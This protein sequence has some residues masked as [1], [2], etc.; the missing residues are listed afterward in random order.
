MR[1]LIESEGQTR[2]WTKILQLPPGMYE[3]RYVVDGHWCDDPDNPETVSSD[4]ESQT[5]AEIAEEEVATAGKPA[6]VFTGYLETAAEPE[7]AV[8]SEDGRHP[9]HNLAYFASFPPSTSSRWL[10]SSR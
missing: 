4:A 5:D 1:S 10:R 6:D 7:T 8:E 9:A 2:V 3:Y